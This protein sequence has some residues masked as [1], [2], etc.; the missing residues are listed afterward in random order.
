MRKLHVPR[1]LNLDM[2]L[3]QQPDEPL[4]NVAGFDRLYEDAIPDDLRWLCHWIDSQHTVDI[5]IQHHGMDGLNRVLKGIANACSQHR[6]HMTPR[7]ASIAGF[8]E[9]TV[10]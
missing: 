3:S 8:Y 4:P 2:L 9:M 5:I 10:W 7:I 6:V 1:G